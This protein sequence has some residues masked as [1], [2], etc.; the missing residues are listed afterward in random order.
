MINVLPQNRKAFF[1]KIFYLAKK[2]PDHETI[3]QTL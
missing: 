3:M 1:W 2:A